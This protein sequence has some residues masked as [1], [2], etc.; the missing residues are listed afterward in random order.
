MSNHEQ[1]LQAVGQLYLDGHFRLKEA[2]SRIAQLESEKISLQRQ[3][4]E[5]LSLVG[6]LSTRSADPEASD[7]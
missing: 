5:A 2:T 3:R 1:V 7:R 4:D 6:T